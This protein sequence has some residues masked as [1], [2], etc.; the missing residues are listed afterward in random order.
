M[1][2]FHIS[3]NGSDRVNFE[4][5]KPCTAVFKAFIFVS[6][7]MEKKRFLGLVDAVNKSLRFGNLSTW[8]VWFYV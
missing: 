8:C 7:S 4:R 5:V 3:E 6:R 1:I 2:C